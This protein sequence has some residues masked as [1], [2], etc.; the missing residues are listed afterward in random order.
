ML[1]L[2]WL[3]VTAARPRDLYAARSDRV[4]PESSR[5]NPF[6]E[7]AGLG[8]DPKISYRE[9]VRTP[10]GTIT[11]YDGPAE[12]TEPPK[13]LLAVGHPAAVADGCLNFFRTL[14]NG[15]LSKRDR[16]L[17]T[18]AVAAAIENAYEWGHHAPT[19]LTMDIAQTDL[20]AIKSGETDKLAKHDRIVVEISQAV[21]HQNVTDELW[22]RAEAEFDTEQLVQLTVISAYYGMLGRIQHALQVDQ[23]EG[24][25][26]TY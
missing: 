2:W 4:R 15:A 10:L 9:L 14:V 8:T 12:N 13:L 5:R 21:E 23:D 17:V 11:S 1:G 6:R 22:T 26:S 25:A 3:Y 19:A 7:Q 16:K 20:D 18:L 24:F